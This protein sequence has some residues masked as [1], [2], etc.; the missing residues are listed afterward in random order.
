MG[1]AFRIIG[2]TDEGLYYRHGDH[3]GSTSVLSDEDG[4][5]VADSE[6]VYA[7]FGEIREGD[8]SELTDFGFTGQQ[9]DRST[10]GLMYYGA[11][12]YLPSLRRFISAD[13]IV[14]GAAN[15]QS[16]NRYSY[17]INNPLVL[18]DPTGHIYCPSGDTDACYQ[19]AWYKAH[20][21]GGGRGGNQPQPE[22]SLPPLI[23]EEVQEFV[24]KATK[25]L[26]DIFKPQEA[27]GSNQVDAV[28]IAQSTVL[29]GLATVSGQAS[30]LSMSEEGKPAG[31]ASMVVPP[32]PLELLPPGDA[33]YASITFT[34]GSSSP[35]T[36]EGD[37]FFNT[38]SVDLVTVDATGESA[39]FIST[40][41]T[42]SPAEEENLPIVT[43]QMGLT[44]TVGELYGEDFRDPEIGVNAYAGPCTYVGGSGP[45]GPSLN[46]EVFSSNDPVTGRIDDKMVGWGYGVGV[47]TGPEVHMY[48]SESKPW[49]GPFNMP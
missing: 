21:N 40:R 16:F 5:K 36:S 27:V 9:L 11:R 39:I 35:P 6:V 34:V 20:K 13:T 31:D 26:A 48:V 17:V 15:P 42:G 4:L 2:G 7:P 32:Q 8:L 47:G 10:G 41:A 12:Y 30:G 3:L 23:P 22:E 44:F 38:V 24:E 49:I 43:P 18:I 14:P 1:G 33:R 46:G 37:L 28:L 45:G 25:D 29:V 19:H